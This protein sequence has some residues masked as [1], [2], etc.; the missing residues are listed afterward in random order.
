MVHA[1]GQRDPTL[2]DPAIGAEVNKAKEPIKVNLGCGRFPKEGFVNVD[3]VKTPGVDRVHNLMELPYPFEDESVELVEADHVLEHL[4][5]CFGIMRD[6]HRMLVPG[7]RVVI[8]VPHFS[9]GFT[10]PEHMRGFDATFPYYFRPD[11]LGGYTGVEFEV[12]SVQYTWFAQPYLKRTVMSPL[13][14]GIGS[15]IGRVLDA[16]A[17]AH[18]LFCSRAWCFYVGG[19]EQIEF[20]MRKPLR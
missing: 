7:G 9:R 16:A 14:A 8:R 19:F 11:F 2:R 15:A 6:V 10:H 4:P 20:R 18:P 12:E 5:D 17:N 13:A 3:W 1:S